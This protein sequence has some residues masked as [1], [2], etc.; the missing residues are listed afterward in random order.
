MAAA[1]SLG[2]AVWIRHSAVRRRTGSDSLLAEGAGFRLAAVCGVRHG[3]PHGVSK[4]TPDRYCGAS[5]DRLVFPLPV[6]GIAARFLGSRGLA[7]HCAR[8]RYGWR[9]LFSTA[10]G[11]VAIPG[12]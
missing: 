12:G 1:V 2:I 4:H 9:I 7:R 3:S 11:H 5:R 6:R 8:D 10:L